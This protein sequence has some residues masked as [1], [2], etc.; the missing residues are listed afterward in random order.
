MIHLLL[1]ADT[2]AQV[3]EWTLGSGN[4]YSDVLV[5]VLIV[6]MV[7]LLATA[8]VVN[9]SFKAIIKLTMPEV[10]AEQAKAV[11]K[12]RDWTAIWNKLLSLRPIEEEKD[13]EI[14]HAYDGIKELNNPIPVWFNALFYS[15]VA[16]AVV[17]LLVYHVFGWGLNQDQEYVQEIARA[18]VAKKA[19]LAQAANLIDE[20]S[21]KIDAS[22]IGEGK[23]IF[24][25]N[26]VVC[27][28]NNGEGGIG[29][30][31]TDQYWLHGGEIKDVFT[32]IKYGVP[33]KGMV[34]W[35]QTLSPGQIAEVANYII[36][37]RGTKPANAK[38][39]QGSEVVYES[40][41]ADEEPAAAETL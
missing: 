15:T 35:E 18:E 4:L 16:F 40:A 26:C 19:Y 38:E 29:P 17:Y 23:S 25:A 1:T 32:V 13:I 37:L 31:L 39:P 2:T 8:L 14:D 34:P 36:T 3:S 30:N 10:A 7:A 11:K 22:L 28:G 33:D 27:H 5:L 12:K 21:V 6:V 41:G 20:N 24:V 9:N